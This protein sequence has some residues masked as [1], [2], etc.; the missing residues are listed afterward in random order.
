[1][2]REHKIERWSDRLTAFG[3]LVVIAVP[4]VV[5][6]TGMRSG[7][8]GGGEQRAVQPRPRLDWSAEGLE[9][10]PARFDAWYADAF[11][12]RMDLVRA[13]NRLEWFGLGLSPARNAVQGRDGWLF[14]S[15]RRALECSLGAYPLTPEKLDQWV[16]MLS[17]R[18]RWCRERG[19]VYLFVS[20]PTKVQLYPEF[21]PEGWDAVGPSRLAQLHSRLEGR[22]DIP[23]L[24]LRPTLAA[25]KGRDRPAVGDFVYYPL[26]THWSM[27]GNVAAYRALVERLVELGA[28]PPG[29]VPESFRSLRLAGGQGDDTWAGRLYLEGEL[30][31]SNWRLPPKRPLLDPVGIPFARHSESYRNPDGTGTL[32]MYHDSYA[33]ILRRWLGWH[34][35]RVDGYWSTAWDMA[36]IEAAS[37]TVVVDFMVERMLH[38]EDPADLFPDGQGR[39]ADLFRKGGPVRLSLE[40]PQDLENEPR[41]LRPVGANRGFPIRQRGREGWGLKRVEPFVLADLD[42]PPVEDGTDLLLAIDLTAAGPTT[43]EVIYPGRNGFDRG[44][45]SRVRVA[46]GRQVVYLR[47]QASRL[48]HLPRTVR[49]GATGP[50]DWILHRISVRSRSGS[51]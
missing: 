50:R 8:G 32:V 34:F 31:Q 48:G 16:R 29:T 20:G 28:L 6:L 38:V 19:I 42:L 22:A 37:P 18:S 41:V 7:G 15:E 47:L 12:L 26:G 46:K 1:M 3:F 39:L 30:T 24:D 21:L 10:Y 27:R 14:F 40:L 9:L 13:H 25:E 43:L 2:A 5:Q 36:R 23:S 35:K 51:G 49:L 33:A 11:G 44:A 4:L 17:A 45:A